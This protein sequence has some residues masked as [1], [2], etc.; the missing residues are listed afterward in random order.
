MITKPS[1]FPCTEQAQMITRQLIP[2][3]KPQPLDK[4][5][6]KEARAVI[7][8]V[9]S[10]FALL[11]DILLLGFI[12]RVLIEEYLKGGGGKWLKSC[13]PTWREK[14]RR[15]SSLPRSLTVTLSKLPAT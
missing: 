2:N 9:T 14:T 13:S 10:K 7:N 4:N 5:P 12:P 6:D 8:P 15:N 3:C 1:S 11:Q